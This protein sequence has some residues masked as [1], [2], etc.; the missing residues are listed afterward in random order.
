M[1]IN[2]N[3][4]KVKYLQKF[5]NLSGKKKEMPAGLPKTLDFL[6]HILNSQPVYYKLYFCK[7]CISFEKW[8]IF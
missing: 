7:N 6:K 5:K 8:K 2:K 3:K 4:N 1:K